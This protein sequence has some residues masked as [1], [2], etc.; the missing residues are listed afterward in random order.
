MTDAERDD[1]ADGAA[2][3]DGEATDHGAT[4]DGGGQ[5]AG[6]G[7]ATGDSPTTGDQQTAGEESNAATG[8]L[9]GGGAID[10][11]GEAGNATSEVLRRVVHA[12]GTVFPVAYLAGVLTWPQ[13]RVVLVVG[14]AVAVV[15]EAL[16]LVGHLEWRIFDLLTRSYEEDNPAG[17][18]L[19]AVGMTTVGLLFEPVIAVPAMLMLTLGDPVSGLLGSGELRDAKRSEAVAGMFAVCVGVA[20]LTGPGLVAA[21]LGGFVAT[22]ADA[23]KPVVAGYVVDDNVTI[24]IGGA[25]AMFAVVEAMALLSGDSSVALFVAAVG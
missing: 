2:A 1:R 19:F 6:D 18:A 17:Y 15:L 5:A 11:E 23:V 22:L 14:T 13:L 20:L 4:A 8:L 3:A 16:R 7:T 25:A 10:H 12:S 9:V 24:P 21:L